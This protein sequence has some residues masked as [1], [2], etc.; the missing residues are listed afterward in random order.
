[1]L[2]LDTVK[3]LEKAQKASAKHAAQLKR[4]IPSLTE[5]ELTQLRMTY[6]TGFLQGVFEAFEEATDYLNRMR[7]N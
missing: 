7:S 1:M 6:E 2:K 5:A 4:D 3:W